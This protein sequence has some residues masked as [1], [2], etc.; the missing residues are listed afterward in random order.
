MAKILPF[1]ALRYNLNKV[2]I[3]NVVAPP[4]DVISEE[5]QNDL[6]KKSEYNVV[7]LILGKETQ[8]DNEK[9]NKY[10]RAAEYLQNWINEQV[11]VQDQKKSIYIYQQ[12]FE[13]EGKK[14][15][16]TGFLC[17][18]KQEPLFGGTIYPHERT[19]S[20]PKANRLNLTRSCKTNFSPI[21]GLY[22]DTNKSIENILNNITNKEANIDLI[23]ESN[24]RN[25]VWIVNDEK[26]VN[27][28][29]NN[30]EDKKIFIADG[31]HRYETAM[32]YCKEMK[33]AGKKG[34]FDHVLAFLCDMEDKGLAVFPTH[35]VARLNNLDFNKFSKNLEMFFEIKKTN[36]ENIK[37]DLE[38]EFNAKNIAFG[39]Y[40]GNE[41]Y[42]VLVLKDK[43]NLDMIKGSKY[44]KELD[45]A[46]LESLIF[47][48]ILNFSKEDVAEQKFLKYI[49]DFNETISVID[50]KKF[51]LAFIMNPTRVEQIKNVSLAGEVMPQK[52]TYFYPKLLT[53]LVI[54]K[55][56]INN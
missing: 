50:D 30:L 35:R 4:Y 25:R 53:G 18:L 41:N 42:S 29:I 52:S 10:S 44:Y 17:L 26:T 8:Q 15:T 27:E 2:D 5:K 7:R 37:I 48:N 40:S 12:D 55:F 6:Y 19:L 3:K 24:E 31:H 46:V 39:L 32:N 33:E 36:K 47:E 56:E 49:K 54:N 22:N 28:I 1:Q 51:E 14:Y 9:I 38:K 11:L 34:N 13:M 20:K 16:R 45:V 23:D 21:F 43:N